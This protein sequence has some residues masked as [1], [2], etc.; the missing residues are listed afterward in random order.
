VSGSLTVQ[1]SDRGGAWK[2]LGMQSYGGSGYWTRHVST[3]AG[4]A[5][6]VVWA[7]PD[8]VTYT[9]PATIAR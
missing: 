1:Y 8:G 9:D 6:R 4:R 2:T 5:W 3:R 7:A